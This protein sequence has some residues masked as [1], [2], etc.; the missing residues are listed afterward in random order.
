VESTPA[1]TFTPAAAPLRLTHR[2]C[3]FPARFQDE[4]ESRGENKRNVAQSRNVK[5]MLYFDE[6]LMADLSRT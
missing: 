3:L 2:Q 5:L 4:L 6:N 1:T